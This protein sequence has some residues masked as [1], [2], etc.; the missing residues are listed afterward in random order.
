MSDMDINLTNDVFNF[1]ISNNMR[2]RS[3][4]ALE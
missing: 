3:K 1:C 4:D 2:L